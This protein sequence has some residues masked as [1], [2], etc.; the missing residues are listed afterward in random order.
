MLDN[1]GEISY[2]KIKEAKLTHDRIALNMYPNPARGTVSIDNWNEENTD[3]EIE[4]FDV[5]GKIVGKYL[6]KGG[7]NNIDISN[8]STGIYVVKAIGQNGFIQQ[9]LVIN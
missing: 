1:S 6:L 2:S 9:K 8:Y 7:S 4:I 3:I 5:T